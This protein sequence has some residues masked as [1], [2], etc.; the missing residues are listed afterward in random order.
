M[1]EELKKR[2]LLKTI[3]RKLLV[4]LCVIGIYITAPFVWLFFV[5]VECIEDLEER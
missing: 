3:G 2:S 4:M 5:V 1:T